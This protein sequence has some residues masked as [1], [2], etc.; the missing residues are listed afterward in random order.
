LQV[1]GCIAGVIIIRFLYPALTTA[2]AAQAVVPHET[3]NGSRPGQDERVPSDG[4]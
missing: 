2:Q 3:G 4:R 1:G